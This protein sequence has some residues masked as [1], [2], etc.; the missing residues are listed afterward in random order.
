MIDWLKMV[1]PFPHSSP[2]GGGHVL[3]LDAAGTVEWQTT[4]RFAVRG[5]YATNLQVRTAHTP[6][7][8]THIEID[9]NPVKF[10]QG[11]NLWGP[12]DVPSIALATLDRIAQILD[13]RV[14]H[15]TRQQWLAGNIA[16]K[17]VDIAESFHLENQAQVLAFIRSADQ[18]AHLAHR[19]RGQL[20][21]GSTLY[22][23]K[24]SRRWA[25]KLYSKGQEIKTKGHGQESILHLPACM[26]WAA[27]TL[28]VELVLRKMGLQ[29]HGLDMLSSWLPVDGVPL[30][31]TAEL[32]RDR[33]GDLT[34][35]TT[36]TLSDDVQKILT[37]SQRNAYL[38][39][40]AGNDL[41][42]TMSK[43]AFYKMR[44]KLLPH[45]IDIATKMP[46]EVSN[47]VPLYR[48]LEAKPAV[49]PSWAYGT[50]LFFEPDLVA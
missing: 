44:S 4:K 50:E 48:V 17:R 40:L 29:Q 12:D 47:V 8:C 27:K 30:T 38:A 10:F 3:S 31:V 18:T 7:Y 43:A 46:K 42:E 28:R 20:T 35:T 9:G 22:F 6:G 45:G 11:H 32:L 41:R 26:E 39:W 14:S 13:I 5:S 15:E 19:G 49:V 25:L 2:I 36:N 37:G 16:L 21:K 34:M 23:G 24:H 1:V 33:L